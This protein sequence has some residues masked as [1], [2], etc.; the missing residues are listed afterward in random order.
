MAT[1]VNASFG[2]E[3]EYEI[4]KPGSKV[5][6][7]GRITFSE[8]NIYL[9]IGNGVRMLYDGRAM[10]SVLFW[11]GVVSTRPNKVYSNAMYFIEDTNTL[12]VVEV[13]NNVAKW[14]N[15]TKLLTKES[16]DLIAQI[17]QELV[18]LE[19]D[20]TNLNS[21]TLQ[22]IEDLRTELTDQN[23]QSNETNTQEFAK[24]REEIT[25]NIDTAKTDILNQV[26]VK[27]EALKT[28]LSKTYVSNDTL[29]K[30][31]EKYLLKEGLNKVVNIESSVANE[32][33]LTSLQDMTAGDMRLVEDTK[34]FYLFDGLK[35]VNLGGNMTDFATQKYV[36][37]EIKKLQAGGIDAY[38]KP[39]TDAKIN[40]VQTSVNTV[41][42]EVQLKAN[43]TDLD[44]KANKVET[45][46]KTEIDEKLK[47]VQPSQS[48]I[49]EVTQADYN[50]LPASE[51]SSGK[52]FLIS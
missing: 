25:K 47:N 17:N 16:L 15:F 24:V 10:E 45:Y 4:G 14:T 52:L 7:A 39:E 23:T 35:W 19:G 2:V 26:D 37:D 41:S 18:R 6:Q 3:L 13:S 22:K 32:A 28:E 51:K 31:L 12:E 20:V 50:N 5:T 42:N 27:I 44:T 38:S 33:T 21:N 30:E 11:G 1:E 34:S 40:A 8:K 43:K 29:T 48:G 36:D 49:V 9:G 46:S